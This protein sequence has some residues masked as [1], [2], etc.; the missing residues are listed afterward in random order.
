FKNGLLAQPTNSGRFSRDVFSVVPEFGI[1]V[2]YQLTDYCTAYVGYNFI[3]WTNVVRPG[4]QI[5][6]SVNPSQLSGNP[7]IG[8]S[9]PTLVARNSDFW[10]QGVNV[11]LAFR[12]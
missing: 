7:L 10:V 12:Y 6:F 2:G 9:R 8:T 1:N 3:Y 4:D 11:G 5:D